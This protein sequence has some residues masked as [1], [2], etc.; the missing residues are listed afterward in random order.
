MKSLAPNLQAHLD[1]G[2]TTLA[3]CWRLTR[4]DGVSFGFTDHDQALNFEDTA[5]EP[6][7]GLTASEIRTGSDLSVDAQDAEGALTSERISEADILAGLWDAAEV[8]VWRVN[9]ADPDQRVLMRRGAIGE[10]RRGQTAFIA[11]IRSLAH[12]LGQTV[13]RMF[14][15]SCDA[16]LG[17]ARCRI[18]L[19]DPAFTGSGAVLE[20]LRDRVF[21]A[22]GLGAFDLG[23]FA[24]GT[25]EW[26]SGEN[27]GRRIEV[28]SH[29]V[30]DGVAILTLLEAPVW[31]IATGDTFTARAGCDKR[32]ETCAAKFANSA[33]FRGFPHIPGQDTI[34]RYATRDGGH[35]GGVL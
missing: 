24:F 29:E 12:I 22:A 32:I 34:L 31:P 5:F 2:T 14:Q 8:E 15:G 20:H 9:W 4:A 26:D 17:D 35:E 27:A 23:W 30:M 21:R 7:S 28:L 10:I 13:G 11:E 3:W 1:S 19:E 6:E 18:D 33:N 16:D 25:V